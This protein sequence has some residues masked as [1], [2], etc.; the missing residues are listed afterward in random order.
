MWKYNQ[1]TSPDELY[2]FD[3]LGMKWGKRKDKGQTTNHSVNRSKA[4]SEYEKH[5]AKNGGHIRNAKRYQTLPV[6]KMTKDKRHSN[7]YTF[8]RKRQTVVA[9]SIVNDLGGTLVSSLTKADYEKGEQLVTKLTDD[10]R[11]NIS[12]MQELIV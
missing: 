11:T 9:K 12:K 3:V 6:S 2:H 8:D 4:E 5:L 10:W 7:Y 1:T